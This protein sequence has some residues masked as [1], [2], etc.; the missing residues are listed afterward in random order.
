MI[1]KDTFTN[2]FLQLCFSRHSDSMICVD[3]KII[4]NMDCFYHLAALLFVYPS[5]SQSLGPVFKVQHINVAV[6]SFLPKNDPSY[7]SSADL[8]KSTSTPCC[9]R[10][11]GIFSW[12]FGSLPHE[13]PLIF[14]GCLGMS[15]SWGFAAGFALR[16]SGY[17]RIQ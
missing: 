11:T 5:Q 3:L 4:P 1:G 16:Q 9:L 7:L 15:S 6:T 12:G 13:G 14:G 10:L 2:L 8:F 17:Q